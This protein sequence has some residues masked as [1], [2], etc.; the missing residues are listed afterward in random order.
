MRPT[1]SP[2]AT[3]SAPTPTLQ[4]PSPFALV[5]RKRTR[6]TTT[7]TTTQIA[8]IYP[9]PGCRLSTGASLSLRGRPTVA[10][11]ILPSGRLWPLRMRCFSSF[12]VAPFVV[13]VVTSFL[14]LFKS[15]CL[16]TGDL[17]SIWHIR[18]FQVHSIHHFPAVYLVGKLIACVN[19]VKAREFLKCIVC[20]FKILSENLY[21]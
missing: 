3:T 9:L 5:C 21:C 20:L 1:I 10:T 7:T 13:I 4:Q 15:C 19:D 14:Y 6:L 8:T 16:E 2:P 18:G 11:C 17:E 12:F